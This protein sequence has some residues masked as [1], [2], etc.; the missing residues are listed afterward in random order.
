MR[1]VGRVSEG[2]GVGGRAVAELH[3]VG[4]GSAEGG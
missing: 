4:Y 2:S 1:S 3:T